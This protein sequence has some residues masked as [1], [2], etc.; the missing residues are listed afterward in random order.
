[1]RTLLTSAC[2]TAAAATVALSAPA[3]YADAPGDNGTV[4]VHKLKTPEDDMRND[5]HVCGFYLDAFHF[6]AQQQVSWK[7]VGKAPTDR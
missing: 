1:M 4:K 5:P 2:L 3:A 7:I 6:D